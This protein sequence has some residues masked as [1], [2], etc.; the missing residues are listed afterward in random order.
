MLALTQSTRLGLTSLNSLGLWVL[1]LTAVAAFVA[2]ERRVASPLVEL[3]LFANRG[4]TAAIAV[5]GSQI[6]CLFGLLLAL[7]VFLIGTQGWNS[8][9]TGLLV[10]PLPLTMALISPLAGRLADLRGSR[11]TCTIGMAVVGLAGLAMLGFQL[12]LVQSSAWWKWVGSLIVMGIGMGLTQSP[13]ASAATQVVRGEQLGVATGIFHMGRFLSGT[14]G[15]TVF[16]LV[17]QADKENVA[18]GF[19][20][21]LW[22][23]VGIAALAVLVARLLP[24]RVEQMTEKI[25]L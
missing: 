8:R 5:I 4:Y 12:D 16:G 3:N 23:L 1:T 14:L 2:F 13:S 6:F 24:G 7:P 18:A 15:T 10:F 19:Q 9:T 11:W 20:H 22:L 17:L 25:A 21:D